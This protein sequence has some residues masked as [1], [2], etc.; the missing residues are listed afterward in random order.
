MTLAPPGWSFSWK[1][2]SPKHDRANE[3]T[4]AK[5]AWRRDPMQLVEDAALP[6]RSFG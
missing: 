4:V 1:C 5:G 2:N 3:L 6:S